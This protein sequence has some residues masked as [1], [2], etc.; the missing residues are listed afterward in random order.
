MNVLRTIFWNADQ[1]RIR[2]GWRILLHLLLWIGIPLVLTALTGVLLGPAINA[3]M[4]IS[5]SLTLRVIG[6]LFTLAG[7]LLGTW[8]ASRAKQVAETP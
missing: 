4:P 3:Y 1:R 7:A 8:I 6:F 5:A 2:A